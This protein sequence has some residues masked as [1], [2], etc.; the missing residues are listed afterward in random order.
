MHNILV[1]E[2]LAL[3]NPLFQGPY[4]PDPDG[5]AAAY[6]LGTTSIVSPTGRRGL[7][8]GWSMIC[9]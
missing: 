9:P 1:A 2:V 5:V 4:S 6:V 8:L 3:R 7:L